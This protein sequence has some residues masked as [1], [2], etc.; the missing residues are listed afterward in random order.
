MR[1]FKN[2]KL[3]IIKQNIMKNFYL[4]ALFINVFRPPLCVC[5][6]G[7]CDKKKMSITLRADVI[8]AFR[9]WKFKWEA[10]QIIKINIPARLRGSGRRAAFAAC[11]EPVRSSNSRRASPTDS[12]CCPRWWAGALP[13]PRTASRRCSSA[14]TRSGPWEVPN[15]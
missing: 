7:Q 8:K 3:K 12:R 14:E 13:R 1:F 6:C 5:L 10:P 15:F 2:N 4:S 9:D 11:P